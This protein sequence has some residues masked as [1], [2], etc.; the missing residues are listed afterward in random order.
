MKDSMMFYGATL[1]QRYTKQQKQIFYDHVYENYQKLGL[2]VSLQTQKKNGVNNIIIGNLSMAQV[3]IVAA[4]DTPSQIKFKA[5]DYYPFN[6]RKNIKVEIRYALIQWIIVSVIF[7][8]F[9]FLLRDFP[10]YGLIAKIGAVI[11]TLAALVFVYW[12]LRNYPNP[13][14]FN[15]NSAALVMIEKIA[16]SFS[17]KSVAY[18]LLDQGVNS[19]LGMKAAAE[20]IGA[21]QRVIILDA[22]ADGEQL[23]V[24]HRQNTAVDEYLNCQ[25]LRIKDKVYSE[26]QAAKNQLSFFK[27]SL[28]LT[29][30][31]ISKNNLVV[32]NTRNI[33][34]VKVD[35][36]RLEKLTDV[37]GRDVNKY[38]CNN[39]SISDGKEKI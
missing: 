2:T 19:Y 25:T 36:E 28:V 29:S 27:K 37:L 24:A 22:L 7:S 4:Y 8:G 26:Q 11:L 12:F 17:Q 30:G 3:I 39:Q 31:S 13:V 35:I 14:N 10:A 15:R 1:G 20:V 34:D 23:V 33:T 16:H 21:D 32:K 6:P 5:V 18:V 9:Y 38:C